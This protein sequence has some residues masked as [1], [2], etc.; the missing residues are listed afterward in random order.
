MRTWPAP[1]VPVIPGHGDALRLE[2]PASA[3]LVVVGGP[4]R[5]A[6]ALCGL[7]PNGRDVQD[8]VA[9][10][11]ADLVVRTWLD[12]GLA[13]SSL[14]HLADPDGA[15]RTATAAD[16]A[17]H[18]LEMIALGVIPPDR[19]VATA[20]SGVVGAV[21]DA[22]PGG[23]DVVVCGSEVPH[24]SQLAADVAAGSLQMP[25]APRD[26]TGPGDRVAEAIPDG[27]SPIAVRLALLAQR[28]REPAALGAAELA[29]AQDRLARWSAAVSGNGGPDPATLVAQVRAAVSDDLDAPRAL[30]A[31]DRW[32]DLA[33]SYGQ[34]GG[35]TDG[36]VIEGAPG[37]AARTVDA[38]LGV[39]L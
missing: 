31:V 23:S 32:A 16:L 26:E 18:S 20:P 27:V 37:V 2:D 36:D 19:I 13:V 7:S 5:C 21:R 29:A 39:R 10:V 12:Q 4:E 22:F 17:S 30:E 9:A 8:V 15:G 24:G 35:L 6:I 28:Y 25:A 1:H 3:E 33:L 14:L 38:L 11:T 34:P